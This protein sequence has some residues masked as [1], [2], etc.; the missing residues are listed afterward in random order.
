MWEPSADVLLQAGVITATSDGSEY[1]ISGLGANPSKEHIGDL[2]TKWLPVLQALKVRFPNEYDAVVQ[3]YYDSFVS[4]QTEDETALSARAKLT[5]AALR[6]L[7]DDAVLVEAG[8]VYAD[9]YS[10]LGAKDLPCA[11]NM[12]PE[13][14]IVSRHPISRAN[15]SNAKTRLTNA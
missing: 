10:A 6:P 12:H 3:A 8:N 4:G 2:L 7:A 5:L 15:L 11:I 14:G 9:Q 1:A 13:L